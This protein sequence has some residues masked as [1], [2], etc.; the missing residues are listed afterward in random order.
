MKQRNCQLEPRAD[1]SNREILNMLKIMSHDIRGSLLSISATL[2]LMT[3]GYYGKIDEGVVNSLKELLSKTIGLIG[4]SEEYLGRTFCVDGDLESEDETLDLMKDVI[5]P[6]LDELSAE[7]KEHHIRMDH[8][9]DAISNTEIPIKA[10]RIGLKAVFRNLL[11]NAI[12]HGGKRSTITIGFKD[13]GSS[14]QVNV[15]NSGKPIPE[16]YRDKLFSKFMRF[17][18]NGNENG[19]THGMGLGLY[20]T[21]KI[22][23]EHGGAIWYEAEENGSNFI[24][25]L[26]SGLL[27]F[28]EPLLPIKPAQQRLA[29]ANM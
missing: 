13:Q 18:N 7:L 28:T 23:E 16:E 29:T 24:F 3:R 2:K 25:T 22:I 27:L 1:R 9:F 4:M 26:P 5:N 19:S 11:R 6:V 21:K 12:K 20:L 17:G 8:R 10:S 15:Y 14:F